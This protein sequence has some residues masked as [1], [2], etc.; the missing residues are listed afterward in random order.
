MSEST[1]LDRKWPHAAG[2]AAAN[3]CFCVSAGNRP[4]KPGLGGKVRLVLCPR[5]PAAYLL[6]AALIVGRDA[7][8]ASLEYVGENA[9]AGL[10][11]AVV[12][13]GY[14]LAHTAQILPLD[15]RGQ[16]V[17]DGSVDAQLAQALFNLEA[18]LAAVGSGSEHLVKL[19]FYVDGPKTASAARKMLSKRFPAPVRPALSWVSTRLPHPKAMLAL[20][21]VAAVPG[22]G[23]RAVVRSDG[24]TQPG[25][26]D[27]AGGVAV[28][29]RGQCV[30]VSGQAEQGDL[31]AATARTLESLLKTIGCL[32]LDAGH[33]VH[34][35]AFLTPMEQ[36]EIVRQQ[37]AKAFAG[38]KPPPLTLVEWSSNLPIEI[39]L[40][41]FAP[42]G[43]AAES[44]DTAS[45][46]TPPGV[47]P[48]PVSSRVARVH[49]GKRIYVS[50]LFA[51][52]AGDG[53]A[54]VRDLFAS[55]QNTLQIAGGDLRHLVKATYYCSDNEANEMLNK[56]RPE[57]YD[58]QRPPAASQAP[59]RGVAVADRSVTMDLI[60]V[61]PP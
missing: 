38:Q 14:A 33:V 57:F 15:H 24:W 11:A 5:L 34:V 32:G 59:V 21:A 45:Y 19:N 60:A 48:S 31:P 1:E 25:Q 2:W 52:K 46:F 39:E 30:Y 7:P 42:A 40:I 10:A 22:D 9:Q 23:P 26:E 51:Q 53:E 3:E 6:A 18:A 58:P 44:R 43:P 12:V 55:L 35:K 47:K 4:R 17:G 16:L 56:V 37:V 28:L 54:Q 29:P 61:T 20:D 41:A 27:A 8:A 13:Q 36:A 49:G 50:G